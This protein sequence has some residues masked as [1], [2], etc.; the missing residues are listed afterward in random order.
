ML[1][2][3]FV[4]NPNQ[5]DWL[6]GVNYFRN[7]LWA[8]H[9]NCDRIIPVLFMGARTPNHIIKTFPPIEVV[10]TAALD[11]YSPWWF[12]RGYFLKILQKDVVLEHIF[13]KARIDVISHRTGNPPMTSRTSIGWIP[14]FQ[15]LHYPEFFELSQLQ[16]RNREFQRLVRRSSAIVLSSRQALRDY[17]SFTQYPSVKSYVLNFAVAPELSTGD[18]SFAALQHRYSI[19]KDYFY[20]PNQFW[21]HK[22]HRVVIDALLEMKK[23]RL[24]TMV[25][26]TGAPVDPRAPNYVSE[27]LE[28]T[29]TIGVED[30]FKVL[31]IVPYDHVRVL[32]ANCL[33][34]INP[35]LFEGWS[36]TVEEAK[37]LGKRLL[38]SNIEVHQEQR[39][40]RAEYF[41]TTDSGSLAALMS[42][43]MNER[44]EQKEISEQ[45]RATDNYRLRF[46]KFGKDYECIIVDL[47]GKA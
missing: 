10:Q 27:L 28:Y 43:V 47:S 39:P 19:D 22:N 46:Q 44:D 8:I 40:D 38:L 42:Q 31:G 1:R 30:R 13:A 14:D 5:N 21:Q 18:V 36:T 20:L 11:K 25:V 32:M 2:I 37:S 12:T 7:L 15:H 16:K 24:D 41:N 45:T 4:V 35:S 34:V 23:A 33:A 9:L 26:S 3:A 29:R 6:G 17:T